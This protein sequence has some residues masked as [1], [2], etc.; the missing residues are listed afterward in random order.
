MKSIWRFSLGGLLIFMSL[1]AVVVAFVARYPLLAFLILGGTAWIL[2]ES[3][4]AFEISSRLSEPGTYTR[5]PFLVA[6]TS[7]LIGGT[8]WAISGFI[9][10]SWWRSPRFGHESW[11][12]WIPI[13]LFAAMGTFCLRPLWLLFRHTGDTQSAT[14]DNE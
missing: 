10:F 14:Q 7:L 2:F 12:V 5:H 1:V 3:G 9:C 11:L 6:G 13:I 8:S 4:L